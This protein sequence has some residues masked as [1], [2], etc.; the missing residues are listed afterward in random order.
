MPP[1]SDDILVKI[2]CTITE[3]QKRILEEEA[4]ARHYNGVSDL[5]RN[6]FQAWI[7]EFHVS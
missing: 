4:L 5:V 7:E 1:K 3:D 2:G 6:I